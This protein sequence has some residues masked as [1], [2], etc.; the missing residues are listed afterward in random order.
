MWGTA[1]PKDQTASCE[2]STSGIESWFKVLSLPPSTSTIV[3]PNKRSSRRQRTIS[4]LPVGLCRHPRFLKLVNGYL[5]KYLH[6]WIADAVLHSILH[7]RVG[8]ASVRAPKNAWVSFG[9][10]SKAGMRQVAGSMSA[11]SSV[12]LAEDT[13]TVYASILK[14]S[15][16]LFSWKR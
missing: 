13:E 6:A 5:A 14:R 9:M 11:V 16:C 1:V 2:T 12:H 4:H 8:G 10:R 15:G 3:L 7:G